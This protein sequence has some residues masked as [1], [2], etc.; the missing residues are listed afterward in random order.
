MIQLTFFK[1]LR[2]ELQ[3][4][5][6]SINREFFP[7]YRVVLTS[8]TGSCVPHWNKFSWMPASSSSSSYT[9]LTFPADV[10]K[11]KNEIMQFISRQTLLTIVFQ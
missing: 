9:V 6:L 10:C 4:V 5:N 2:R 11:Q 7:I 8:S 3:R 1:F